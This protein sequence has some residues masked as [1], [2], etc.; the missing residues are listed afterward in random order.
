MYDDVDVE[1]LKAKD[2]S[3]GARLV[4]AR[5]GKMKEEVPFIVAINTHGWVVRLE[6][7]PLINVEDVLKAEEDEQLHGVADNSQLRPDRGPLC[8][9]HPPGTV[10]CQQNQS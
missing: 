4:G 2:S 1:G 3:G 8:G 10:N 5:L 6:T 9:V 7:A